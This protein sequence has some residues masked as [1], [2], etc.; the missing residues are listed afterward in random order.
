MPVEHV[1]QTGFLQVMHIHL[2]V[3]CSM[4]FSMFSREI[5]VDGRGI[6]LNIFK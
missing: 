1:P 3:S 4:A 6:D 5:S 2:V